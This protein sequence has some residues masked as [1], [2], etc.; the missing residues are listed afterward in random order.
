MPLYNV[1]LTC[2]HV[3][4]PVTPGTTWGN[5]YTLAH[6]LILPWFASTWHVKCTIYGMFS[7]VRHAFFLLFVIYPLKL[8]LRSA[9]ARLLYQ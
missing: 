9:Q 2:T 3:H 7:G 1:T 6:M 4:F 8:V 5:F